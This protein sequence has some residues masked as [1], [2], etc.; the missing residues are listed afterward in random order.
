MAID[1]A[2]ELT[3]NPVYQAVAKKNDPNSLNSLDLDGNPNIHTPNTVG[4]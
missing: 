3:A 2:A 4:I 1:I